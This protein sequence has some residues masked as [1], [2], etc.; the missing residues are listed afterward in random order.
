MKNTKIII[1]SLLILNPPIL[2]CQEKAYKQLRVVEEIPLTGTQHSD[3]MA[4]T[5]VGDETTVKKKVISQNEVELYLRDLVT[6][7]ERLLDKISTSRLDRVLVFS[8]SRY[9]V[10]NYKDLNSGRWVARVHDLRENTSLLLQDEA[11][12][13]GV[14]VVSEIDGRIMYQVRAPGLNSKIY[15]TDTTG[16]NPEYVVEGIGQKWLPNGT[17]FIV[18]S[19]RVH[20]KEAYRHGKISR[21]E[22]DAYLDQLKKRMSSGGS[23]RTKY[24][25]FH[26]DLKSPVAIP[27]LKSPNPVIE[28]SP[29]ENLFAAR[30]QGLLY[31]QEFSFLDGSIQFSQ[32]FEVHRSSGHNEVATHFSWNSD[33]QKLAYTV[34]TTSEDGEYVVNSDLYIFDRLQNVS[35][36]LTSTNEFEERPVWTRDDD[37]IVRKRK[38]RGDDALFVKLKLN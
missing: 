2:F 12:D 6:N 27:D 28:F 36:A 20:P 3:L 4:S 38:T 35:Y 23:D 29:K 26:K 1:L 34:R 21:A 9:V 37:I 24:L 10:V 8:T 30:D 7:S 14:P 19:A 32:R 11:A 13:I 22:Y 31:I 33:G 16:K 5:L 25:F 17:G 18:K 15:V